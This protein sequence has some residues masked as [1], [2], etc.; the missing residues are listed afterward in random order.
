MARLSQMGLTSTVVFTSGFAAEFKNLSMDGPQRGEVDVTHFGSGNYLEF[1]PAARSDL[2]TGTM[3][4]NFD[5]ESYD[6]VLAMVSSNSI[7]TVT[8]TYALSPGSGNTTA[9]TLVFNCYV[10]GLPLDMPSVD[11]ISASIALRITGS[12]TFTPET[13]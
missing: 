12:Y 8:V 11:G 4:I 3:D 9:A 10:T 7:E 1:D 6:T 13:A 5:P 2:Q